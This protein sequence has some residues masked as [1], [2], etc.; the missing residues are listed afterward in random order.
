MGLAHSPKIVTDGLV[1]CLDAAD[2]KSY[3]GSG[4]AW[5]DRSGNGNDATLVNGPTFSTTNGGVIVFDGSDDYATVPCSQVVGES[6]ISVEMVSNWRINGGGMFFGFYTY[7]VYTAGGRL[8]YNNGQSN[9]IGIDAS[10]VSSL[11]LIGSYHHYVFI[12]NSSGTLID[13]KIY[14]DGVSQTMA[15]VLNN[16]GTC[17]AFTSS[18]RINSWNN[19]GYSGD[20]DDAYFRMYAKELTQDEVLQNYN[21][22]KSRFL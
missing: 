20:N 4:T 6:T 3:S 10:T 16:D 18:M 7:D 19:G 21:A 1:L 9:I 8:G 5:T 22:T 14:I 13:N 12:M 17:R 2:P 15:A 11:G